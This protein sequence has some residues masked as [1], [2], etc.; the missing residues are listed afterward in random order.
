[1]EVKLFF[2]LGT[3]SKRSML[4]VKHPKRKNM[5]YN[6]RQDL[7]KRLSEETGMTALECRNQLIRERSFL[8]KQSGLNN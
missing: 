3:C 6:P 1:M 8:R 2:L 4:K 7:C 5:N